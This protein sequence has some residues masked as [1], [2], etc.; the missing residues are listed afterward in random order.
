MTSASINGTGNGNHGQS[1]YT[2]YKEQFFGLCLGYHMKRESRFLKSLAFSPPYFHID[3]NAGPGYNNI[4]RTVGTPILFM[5]QA[6]KYQRLPIEARFIEKKAGTVEQLRRRITQEFGREFNGGLFGLDRRF[7]VIR[8]DNDDHLQ[9][10]MTTIVPSLDRIAFARGSIISDPTGWAK[11]GGAVSLET[12]QMA[13][14][15]A[16]HFLILLFFPYA[17]AKMVRGYARHDAERH[18]ALR[19]VADFLPLRPHWLVSEP[20]G[21]RVC[22]CGTCTRFPE[23]TEHVPAFHHDSGRGREIIESCDIIYGSHKVRGALPRRIGDEAEA[24]CAI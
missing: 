12:L 22:L 5:R 9:H 19:T 23:G 21:G 2:R 11:S 7:G 4:S 15:M 24:A 17:L 14:A 20:T 8:G 10:F 18:P 6:V 16:P 13:A 3:L 1:K